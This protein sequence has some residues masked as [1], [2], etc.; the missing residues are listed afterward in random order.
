MVITASMI[1]MK[2]RDDLFVPSFTC[3]A[4]VVRD[5]DVSLV[6]PREVDDDGPVFFSI[7]AAFDDGLGWNTIADVVVA[8]AFVTVDFFVDLVDIAAAL[9]DVAALE[10]TVAA[11]LDAPAALLDTAALVSLVHGVATAAA[12]LMSAA[13]SFLVGGA[14]ALVVVAALAGTAA[15]S[16]AV[17]LTFFQASASIPVRFSCACMHQEREVNK[18]KNKD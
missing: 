2:A 9:A 6:P 8:A 13:G 7:L 16:F 14:V 5:V 3:V 11:L 17:F 12:F 18:H 10:D 15:L 1:R 4:G